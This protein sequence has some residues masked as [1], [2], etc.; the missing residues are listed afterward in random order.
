MTSI[1]AAI[2]WLTGLLPGSLA[3]FLATFAI[4]FVG[5]RLMSGR[6]MVRQGALIVLGCF[7]LLGSG[8][9]AQSLL[10]V[11]YVPGID[12]GPVPVADFGVP[13]PELRA[14]ASPEG[15]NPFDP[16]GRDISTE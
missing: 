11:A 4:A 3:T 16:Y 10:D 6:M 14:T 7:I 8:L 5:F 13:P 9:I 2:V 1:E 12:D 15:G